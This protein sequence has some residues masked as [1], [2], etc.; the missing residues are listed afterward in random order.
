MESRV[1]L[2]GSQVA[3]VEIDSDMR[4]IVSAGPGAGKTEVVAALVEH[5]LEDNGADP[6]DVA[7]IAFSNA[8]VFAVDARLRASGIDPITVQTLDS[9][10]VEAI[11]DLS[12]QETAGMAFDARISEADR[13]I[14]EQGWERLETVEHL[15]VD[16][17]QDVVGVRADFLLTIIRSLPVDA[18]FTALGDQAQSIYDFQ[19]RPDKSDRKPKSTTTSRDLIS[20][21]L[22]LDGVIE[23]ELDGQYRARSRDA[24]SAAGLRRH[25][26]DGNDLVIDQYL[27]GVTRSGDISQVVPLAARWPGKTAFLTENN[28]QA[29]LVADAIA[30][31][32]TTVELRQSSQQRVI[33]SWVAELLADSRTRSVS[34]PEF[35]N[36]VARRSPE[37]DSATLWRALRTVHGGRGTEIDIARIAS[38]LRTP[39]PLQPVFMDAPGAEYIVSTVHRAKGLEFDNVVLVDFT[40]KPWA[41]PD[42]SDVRGS[43]FVALTRARNLIVR[44]DGP[45]DR[46]L[47]LTETGSR[48]WFV[49]GPK[50]WM[51]FGIELRVDDL[52]RSRPGG[53]DLASTQQH[54]EEARTGDPLEF[55]LDRARSTLS[56]PIYDVVHDRAIVGSTSVAFGEDLARR[57]RSRV[58]ARTPWPNLTGGRLESVGT[59]AGEP[60]QSTIGRHG[61]WLAPF[62]VGMLGLKWEKGSDVQ[63]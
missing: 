16:E 56:V 2:D 46:W 54:L 33:A 27:A 31:C 18:G 41:E 57:V 58:R 50:N 52:D 1:A 25:V 32:G 38:R 26:A 40:D 12:G 28:G 37:R 11:H 10:A 20:E 42:P 35:D 3:V 61:L 29:L 23:L 7:V 6:A 5:L 8:A 63:A 62:A 36:L 9:L 13:L 19:L 22:A 48:R 39:R 49:T 53:V 14:A 43:R 45:N 17:L 34:R 51:T 24:K 55:Q 4:Q 44:A 30:A 60:Q 47:R 15:I 21:L 59:V